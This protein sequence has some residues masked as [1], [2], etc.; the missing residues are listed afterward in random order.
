[1]FAYRQEPPTEEDA[2][3]AR[4]SVRVLSHYVR[5]NRSLTVKL[6]DGDND[7]L[8]ALPASAVALLVDILGAMAAGQGI[9]LIPQNAELTT[10]Q[11]AEILN[12]SRPFLIKLLEAKEIPFRKV[13]KHRRVLMRDI[14][15]YKRK[16]DREREEI[17]DQLVAEAQE[18]DMGYD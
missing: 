8:I 2:E 17:L 6:I 1:M 11:A 13:G 12:V 18:L 7:Q 16:I 9:T 3:V 5:K 15:A 14:M 10:V 4:N